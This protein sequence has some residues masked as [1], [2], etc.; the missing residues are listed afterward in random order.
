M[1]TPPRPGPREEAA[2]EDLCHHPSYSYQS[3]ASL[4]IVRIS[5]FLALVYADLSKQSNEK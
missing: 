2:E 4:I 5:L 3:I 1:E